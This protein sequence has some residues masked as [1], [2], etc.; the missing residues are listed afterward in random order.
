V[1]SFLGWDGY[2]NSWN[3]V[4]YTLGSHDDIGDQNNGDAEEGLTKWDSRHRYFTDLFGGR[5]N[6]DARAKARMGWALTAT[7]PGTPMMFMGTEFHFNPPW[8]YWHDGSDLNGDHR[9]NWAQAADATAMPMRY[10]V[11][12]VNNVRWQNSALR[13]ETLQITQ[14][15]TVN[16]VIAFKRWDN[17]AGN[18]VLTIV[19]L[20]TTSFAN[21]DY[22]VSTGGQTGQ[23]TQ[24]F[25]SQD[26]NFGG[27]DGSGNAYYD[28]YTQGDGKIYINLP[29]YSVIVMKIK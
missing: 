12:A 11:A 20:G 24:L 21:H 17:G 28:P 1:K 7:M 6:W 22:G 3:L 9:I 10:M 18:I 29:K 26:A 16:N 25:C 23:W 14:E 4:K 15:D 13:S 8:G 27:W 2:N 19:N 5:D